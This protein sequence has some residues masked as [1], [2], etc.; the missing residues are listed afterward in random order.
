MVPDPLHN[1]TEGVLGEGWLYRRQPLPVRKSLFSAAELLLLSLIPA[2][3]GMKERRSAM[4]MDVVLSLRCVRLPA[5]YGRHGSLRLLSCSV[6]RT[7]STPLSAGSLGHVLSGEQRIRN[8]RTKARAS[9][10]K[11]GQLSSGRSVP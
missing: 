11:L 8:G 1:K 9:D 6:G 7:C 4:M 10:A 3:G 5:S 2:Q